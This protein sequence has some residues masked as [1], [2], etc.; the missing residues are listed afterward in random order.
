MSPEEFANYLLTGKLPRRKI[1]SDI[2]SNAIEFMRDNEYMR[3]SYA[4]KDNKKW[5]EGN[6]K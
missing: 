1:V 4:Y 3:D 6:L 5:F 2:P